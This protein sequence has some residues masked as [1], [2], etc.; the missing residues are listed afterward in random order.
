[1][2]NLTLDVLDPGMFPYYRQYGSYAEGGS[3]QLV[4]L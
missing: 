4:D 2:E 1:M 3:T